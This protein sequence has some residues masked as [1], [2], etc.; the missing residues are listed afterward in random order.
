MSCW[1]GGT[2]C[3]TSA[4]TQTVHVLELDMKPME[5]GEAGHSQP[6]RTSHHYSACAL[7]TKAPVGVKAQCLDLPT[8]CLLW[9]GVTTAYPVER[10]Q[11]AFWDPDRSRY[12]N[13]VSLLLILFGFKVTWEAWKCFLCGCSPEVLFK[14]ESFKKHAIMVLKMRNE[15]L[16]RYYWKA[17][18][19]EVAVLYLIH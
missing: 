4:E 8:F 10:L 3:Y 9:S 17:G 18:V 6:L 11:A 1:F 19:L 14:H 12:E 15:F 2:V 5:T 16:E 13:S 7:C